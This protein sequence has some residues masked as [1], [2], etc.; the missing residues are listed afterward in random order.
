MRD[1]VMADEDGDLIQD[2]LTRV[3]A[4][5]MALDKSLAA[6]AVFYG[7]EA[8]VKL[9]IYA[10]QGLIQEFKE[11]GYPPR[12]GRWS[13][14]RSCAPQLMRSKLSLN[15]PSRNLPSSGR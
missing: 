12:A 11:I 6:L 1:N 8:R 2:L 5:K 10:R 14:Q 3:E 15:S 9:E 7:D 4:L 13:T